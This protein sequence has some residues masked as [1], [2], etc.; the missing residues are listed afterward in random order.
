[1][2]VMADVTV[3]AASG[4]PVC[5]PDTVELYPSNPEG[6]SEVAWVLEDGPT[7]AGLE[8]RWLEKC[9]FREMSTSPDRRRVEGR[10]NAGEIGEFPYVAVLTDAEG[11][12]MARIDPK[13]VNR[14]WP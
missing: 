14:P 2:A 11:R 3:N 8:I 6:P 13:I 10:E 5:S 4:T 1:M 12:E 9:P 7:A